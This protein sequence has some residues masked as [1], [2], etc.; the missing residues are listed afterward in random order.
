MKKLLKALSM[1][2]LFFIS[3]ESNKNDWVNLFDGESLEGWEMK[4][5]G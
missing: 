1:S 4:I 2:S 5:K 3:C